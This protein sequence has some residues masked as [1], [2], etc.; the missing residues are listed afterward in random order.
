MYERFYVK[1]GFYVTQ[2]LVFKENSWYIIESKC[3]V[4]GGVLTATRPRRLRDENA[5]RWISY[6]RDKPNFRIWRES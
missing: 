3:P 6:H 2:R 1:N 5:A 4:K